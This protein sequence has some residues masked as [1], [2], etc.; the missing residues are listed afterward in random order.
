MI[1]IHKI[2]LI[3]LFSF[4]LTSPVLAADLNVSCG[5][6]SCSKNGLDPLFSS[7]DGFWYPGRILTKILNLKNSGS[8]VYEMALKGTRVG[9]AGTLEDKMELSIVSAGAGQVIWSGPLAVFYGLEKVLMGTF[10]SG[11]DL[12]YNLTVSMDGSSDNTYQTL[13]SSFD[14]G[15]GFW[16]EALIPTPT[17]TPDESGGGGGTGGTLGAGVNAPSCND[18]QPS[19]PSNLSAIAGT[20]PGQVILSWNPPALPYTYFLVAYSDTDSPKWGNP[21]IG[22]STSYTVSGLGI[23]SYNFWVRAGNGC[24]PGNFAGPVSL[25]LSEGAAGVS[26]GSIAPGF[27]QGVLGE[28]TPSAEVSPTGIL[29]QEAPPTFPPV[30]KLPWQLI[31]LGGGGILLLGY[32]FIFRR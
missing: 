2:L 25:T 9:S 26:P 8:G 11:A 6:G 22:P 27:S 18:S 19:T 4:L 15:T 23:G 24:M 31:V 7:S 12:D 1:K 20:N 3:I 17:P 30:D 28:S 29:G 32:F 13:T 10:G 5:G 16:G 14:L 21:N